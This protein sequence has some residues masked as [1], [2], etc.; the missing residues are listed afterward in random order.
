MSGGRWN[1]IA[2]PLAQAHPPDHVVAAPTQPGGAGAHRLLVYPG[3]GGELQR[4][5]QLAHAA[6]V[7]DQPAQQLLRLTTF[8]G[9]LDRERPCVP[10]SSTDAHRPLRQQPT[11]V[12]GRLSALEQRQARTEGLLE[13]VRDAITAQGL[14][15]P[16][17]ENE[18]T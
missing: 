3:Q 16:R 10:R 6:Q 9:A 4:I 13:A 11:R 17:G 1:G 5:D 8:T 15:V 12:E 2:G 7:G 14:V 18:A